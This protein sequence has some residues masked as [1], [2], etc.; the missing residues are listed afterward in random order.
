M[1]QNTRTWISSYDSLIKELV[2][3]K[4]KTIK[5]LLVVAITL[6][7]F[8]NSFPQRGKYL[9]SLFIIF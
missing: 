7:A 8:V 3:T 6:F 9:E 5:R 2:A 1:I 4:M